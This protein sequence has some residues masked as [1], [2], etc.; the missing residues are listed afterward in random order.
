MTDRSDTPL[1][2]LQDVGY[3]LAYAF[4]NPHGKALAWDWLREHWQWLQDNLA[5][6]MVYSRFPLYAAR[7]FSSH[8]HLEAYRE[9]FAHPSEASQRRYEAL[10]AVFLEERTLREVAQ[11]QGISYGTLRN[12]ASEF[13][14]HCDVGLRPPF[15]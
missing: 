5:S 12:W 8:A 1:V 3:W 13:R 6:D 10:R 15:S 4:G 2:R 11:C 14:A 7:P 9:F